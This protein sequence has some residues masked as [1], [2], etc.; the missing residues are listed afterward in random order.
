VVTLD[1]CPAINVRI[2]HDKIVN[3]TIG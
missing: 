1:R 2:Q 3:G